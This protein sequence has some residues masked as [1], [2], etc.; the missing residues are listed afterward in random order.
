MRIGLTLL[1]L[2]A[3]LSACSDP[4]KDWSLATRDD[5]PETYLEFLAKHPESA[6]ADLARQ[7]IAELKVI[8]AWERAEFKD[9][10]EGYELFIERHPDSEFVAEAGERIAVFARDEQWEFSSGSNDK[11]ALISFIE[12]WPDAPQ[13]SM[14]EA[15]LAEI[16]LAEDAKKPR[17]RPGAFRLQLAAFRSAESADTELR[18]LIELFPNN[19][20]LGPVRIVTPVENGDSKLFLLK[21]VPMTSNEAKT[22]C[23]KLRARGQQCLVI[24]K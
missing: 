16:Q 10:P 9:S 1:A 22:L 21:T 6:Q 14:A 17:E 3:I 7:R 8:N 4:D 23:D 13:R 20:L 11:T 18:R 2:C 12:D 19:E 15:E 5:A 24:N